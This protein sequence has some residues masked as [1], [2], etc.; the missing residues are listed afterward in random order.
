MAGGLPKTPVSASGAG[1]RP[2]RRGS[3]SPAYTGRL[4]QH[5]LH[6]VAVDVG[7][8]EVAALVAVG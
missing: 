2:T 5:T 1:E 3:E 8:A 7:Q 4:R 6:H